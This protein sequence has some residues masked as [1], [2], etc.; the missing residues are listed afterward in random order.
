MRKTEEELLF[1]KM[2]RF[3]WFL[4]GVSKVVNKSNEA[5]KDSL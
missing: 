5:E 1:Y 2:V 3:S 4:L